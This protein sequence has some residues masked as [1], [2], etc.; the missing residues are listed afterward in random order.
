MTSITISHFRVIDEEEFQKYYWLKVLQEVINGLYSVSVVNA[1]LNLSNT[2]NFVTM[3]SQFNHLSMINLAINAAC[4][5]LF[6]PLLI[7][8]AEHETERLTLKVKQSHLSG[9]LALLKS[10]I[11][12]PRIQLTVEPAPAKTLFQ[13]APAQPAR[14]SSPSSTSNP[15]CYSS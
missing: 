1:N 2:F 12:V 5:G 13:P 3:I 8:K 7:E 10:Q 15:S 14:S 6:V 4:M 9:K 11:I